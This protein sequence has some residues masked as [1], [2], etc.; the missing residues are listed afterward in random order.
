MKI[1]EPKT[2]WARGYDSDE[3]EDGPGEIPG[4]ELGEPERKVPERRLSDGSRKAVHVEDGGGEVHE[5]ESAEEKEKHRRFEE[6]RKR[7][8]EM[9]G[10]VQLLGHTEEMMDEDTDGDDGEGGEKGRAPPPVPPVPQKFQKV[11]GS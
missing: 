4:L 5:G 10:A 11:N 7:H 9:K 8:Y 1:D 3:D 2:P 6:L